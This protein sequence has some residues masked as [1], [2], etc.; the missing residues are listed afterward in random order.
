[1]PRNCC[2]GASFEKPLCKLIACLLPVGAEFRDLT[3]TIFDLVAKLMD[4]LLL[5]S[6]FRYPFGVLHSFRLQ[7]RIVVAVIV[8]CLPRVLVN[9]HNGCDS[10][11][12]ELPI[13]RDNEHCTAIYR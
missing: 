13:M 6:I 12:Q 7:I 2:V 10:A 3:S 4:F 8:L 11:V 1:T 5:G 9:L